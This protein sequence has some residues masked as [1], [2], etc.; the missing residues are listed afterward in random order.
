MG[1]VIMDKSDYIKKVKELL[2][3]TSTYRPLNVDPNQ[4]TEE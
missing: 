1:L 4:Q 2:E 3:D